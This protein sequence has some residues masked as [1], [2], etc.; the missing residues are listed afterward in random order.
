[1]SAGGPRLRSRPILHL[2][3]LLCVS[4]AAFTLLDALTTWSGA[5]GGVSL[6]AAL[7]DEFRLLVLG[8]I[9]KPPSE[10]DTTYLCRG[11]DASLVPHCRR[12]FSGREVRVA[13]FEVAI[14]AAGFRDAEYPLDKPPGTYRIF[15]LG[16][17]ITFGLGVNNREAYPEV[18]ERELN[19]R[20]DFPI[21]VL[22]LGLPGASTDDELVRLRGFMA[23]SPDFLLLQVTNN[24]AYECGESWNKAIS[25]LG[26][27]EADHETKYRLVDRYWLGLPHEERCGCAIGY[28]QEIVVEARRAGIP[29]L[30]VEFGLPS[31]ARSCYAVEGVTPH[32]LGPLGRAYQL[33]RMD[34]HPNSRGHRHLAEQLLPVLIGSVEES[35]RVLPSTRGG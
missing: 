31:G 13:P 22:N 19:A 33:S 6:R 1:M 32:E 24:D 15:A 29:L 11:D 27:E 17:S 14:N 7:M 4:G 28:L 34:P 16:D 30:V 35:G 3:L 20:L 8:R 5:L 18:L 10:Q 23:Y 12:T 21:E 25:T 2:V 9:W 26:I